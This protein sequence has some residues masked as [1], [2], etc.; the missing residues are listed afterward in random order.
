MY[1]KLF[2]KLGSVLVAC[3]LLAMPAPA[4]STT[5]SCSTTWG[6]SIGCDDFGSCAFVG[7]AFDE[8]SCK[9]NTIHCPSSTQYDCKNIS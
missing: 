1:R 9:D 6:C 4:A 7:C 8:S 5:M 3:S 2:L